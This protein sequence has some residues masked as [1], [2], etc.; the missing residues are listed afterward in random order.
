M[1]STKTTKVLLGLIFLTCIFIVSTTQRNDFL[2]LF[3]AYGLSFASYL[4][5]LKLDSGRSSFKTMLFIAAGAYSIAIAFPPMLSEDYFRFLWDGEL[6]SI[7][8][9]PFDS[10]PD[11]IKAAGLIEGKV[12]MQELYDNI[13][14]LSR[15]HFSCYPPLSQLYFLIPALISENLIVSTIVLKILIIGTELIGGI[16]LIKLLHFMNLARSRIWVL[17]LNPLW[18]IEANTNMHFEGVMISLLFIAFYHMLKHRELIGSPFFALAIQI[19][20]IPLMLL[21]FFYRFLGIKRSLLFYA[22]TI[23]IVVLIGI[24]MINLDNYENFIVSLK[25]YFRVFE[26]NSFVLHYYLQYGWAEYG[27]NLI[28][29]YV[30]RLSRLAIMF[31]AVLSLYGEITDWKK[32]FRRMT[33]AFFIYLLLSATIH[34]W[35]L[36]PLLGL[37][38]FT[39]YSFPIVWSFTIFFSYLIYGYFENQEEIRW[40]INTEYAIVIVWFI[41]EVTLKYFPLHFLRLDTYDV[42]EQDRNRSLPKGDKN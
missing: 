19:K 12:F 26:F 33:I 23:V 4:G 24:T 17:Y 18:L 13:T 22:S 37:G 27:W 35:Y 14:V 8:L 20:L 5:L 3:F 10:T 42:L 21:P 15:R 11:E 32:L 25:L 7:G 2:E 6:A 28:Y 34:P 36:L 41:T 1:H 40:I 16:Y 30:P 29:A 38:L 39:N 31:I 9:N